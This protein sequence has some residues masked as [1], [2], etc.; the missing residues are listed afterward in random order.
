MCQEQEQ[1]QEQENQVRQ[2]AALVL[3]AIHATGHAAAL[4]TA[5]FAL[6]LSP[7]RAGL[8]RAWSGL[9]QPGLRY[10]QLMLQPAARVSLSVCVHLVG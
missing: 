5:V 9:L 6:A 2:V 1:E 10:A 7:A 8:A 4:W 3:E